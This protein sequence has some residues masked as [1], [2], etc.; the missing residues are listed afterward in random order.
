MVTIR[1][2]QEQDWDEVWAV[3]AAA[4]GREDE[5]QV[6]ERL[7]ENGKV[8]V[9]L[10]AEANG[11]LVGH[12]LFSPVTIGQQCQGVGLGPLAVLPEWQK[13]GV[14]KQLSMAGIAACRQLGHTRLVVLGHPT[15]YPRFGFVPA[16]R[17]GLHSEYDVPDEV[18][19]AQELEEG[20]FAGCAGLV[21]YAPEF[22][23]V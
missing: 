8:V 15:Y 9:S 21:R 20:A 18:F 12:I 5:A 22:E 16:S 6:V 4:F 23:G 19:M 17:F 3:E 1:A 11:R 7:R 2:E 14:G 13:K 10:V